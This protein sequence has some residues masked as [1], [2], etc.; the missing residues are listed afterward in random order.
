VP[1]IPVRLL[2]ERMVARALHVTKK[3]LKA[4]IPVESAAADSLHCLLDCTNV[5]ATH[6]SFYV[7]MSK[8]F[9]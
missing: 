3:V 5:S 1:R 9:W 2:L 4:D 7:G 8:P 6:Q